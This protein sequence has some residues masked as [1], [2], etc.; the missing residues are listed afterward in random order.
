MMVSVTESKLVLLSVQQANKWRD[1]GARNGEFIWKA[2]RLRRWQ[3]R[4]PKNS[5]P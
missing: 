4:V 1:V 2:S 5:L 3:T